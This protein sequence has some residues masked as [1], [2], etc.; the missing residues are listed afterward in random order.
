MAD[1]PEHGW[2]E[3][4]VAAFLKSHPER[5]PR[6]PSF[7]PHGWGEPVADALTSLLGIKRRVGHRGAHH[8]DQRETRRTADLR[9][10]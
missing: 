4:R 5:V 6:T 10:C 8:S 2:F 3:P 7:V 1:S 9:G